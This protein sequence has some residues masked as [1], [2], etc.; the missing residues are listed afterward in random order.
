MQRFQDPL[1]V[2]CSMHTVAVAKSGGA[3]ARGKQLVEYSGRGGGPL[4]NLVWHVRYWAIHGLQLRLNSNGIQA[5]SEYALIIQSEKLS[6]ALSLT[7]QGNKMQ[8][9]SC[10]CGSGLGPGVCAGTDCVQAYMRGPVCMAAS[11]HTD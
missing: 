10:C 8:C 4:A 5:L 7:G 2:R 6:A 1:T 9:Q 11:M 3:R